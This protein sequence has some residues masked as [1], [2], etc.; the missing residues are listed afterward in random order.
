MTYKRSN[1]GQTDLVYWFVIR[2]HQQVRSACR[3]TSLC[4]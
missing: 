2:V 3:I 1:P 4:M